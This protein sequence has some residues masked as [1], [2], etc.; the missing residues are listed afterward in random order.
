MFSEEYQSAV[1][2]QYHAALDQKRTEY[3]I[4]ELIW[5][6]AD[7]M[8]AEGK[9]VAMLKLFILPNSLGRIH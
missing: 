8:T 1:L 4:G 5:N 2:K 9:E 7:F 6:F 3:V